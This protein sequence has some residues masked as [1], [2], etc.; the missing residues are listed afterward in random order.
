MLSYQHEYHAGNKADILKHICLTLILQSLCKKDKAFTVIDTHAS[1]GRFFLNDEKLVKTGEAVRGIQKLFDFYKTSSLFLPEGIRLYLEKEEPYLE[2]GLYAG[3]PE[4]ERLFMRK[5]DSLFLI[6]KH[7]QALR[8]LQENI[9][10]DILVNGE[11]GYAEKKAEVRAFVKN[12]DS[13][14][15]LNAL[16]PPKIKRG[17]IICDPSF[18]DLSDYKQVT[19]A[20]SLARKKWNTGIIALWYPILDHKKNETAKMLSALED[21]AKLGLNPTSSFRCEFTFEEKNLSGSGMLVI[22]PP[23]QLKEKLEESISLLSKLFD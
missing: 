1:V 15:S 17:L 6:E 2:K 4:L 3:S 13:Y 16:T 11:N 12:A 8:A 14:E 10:K 22:N 5:G 20:L 23:W 18:E 19:E 7:P 21:M 9:E